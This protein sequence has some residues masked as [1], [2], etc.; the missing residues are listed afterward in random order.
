MDGSIKWAP[1][2][3]FSNKGNMPIIRDWKED[4]KT[5]YEY[6]PSYEEF[7]KRFFYK[8]HL[9]HEGEFHNC[10]AWGELTDDEAM[11][12]VEADHQDTEDQQTDG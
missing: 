2:V 12:D 5:R 1:C 6:R 9:C 8:W 11:Y 10:D 4:R 3:D 7:S